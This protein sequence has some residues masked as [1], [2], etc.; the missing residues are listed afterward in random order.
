MNN[1]TIITELQASA[2]AAV[3]DSDLP[4]LPIK[5]INVN[6]DKP[7]NGKWLELVHIPNSPPDQYWGDEQVW[8]GIFRLILHWPNDG[9]GSYSAAALLD[10]I[11]AYYKK[12]NRIGDT[13]QLINKP[14]LTS[15]IDQEIELLLPVSLEY[16]AFST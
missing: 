16:Q 4:T 7:D 13:L 8:R 3:A 9:G 10:S 12:S 15:M 14:K 6:F 1:Q 2:I 5:F 11:I